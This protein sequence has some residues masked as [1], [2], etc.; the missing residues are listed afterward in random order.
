[1]DKFRPFADVKKALSVL[2]TGI[3][4]EYDLVEL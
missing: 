3:E 1:M 2:I 4:R